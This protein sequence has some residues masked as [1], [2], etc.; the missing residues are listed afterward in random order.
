MNALNIADVLGLI[1]LGIGML[2]GFRR[3]LVKKG[4][5]LVLTLVTLFALYMVSPYV[6]G[7]F[8]QILP[9]SLLPDKITGTDSEL[10][11]MLLLSGFGDMAENYV[12]VLAAKVL[13]LVTTY[14]VIR[15]LVRTL[16][17]S[18]NILTKVPGLSL[19]NRLAGAC[20]GLVLQLLLLW[21]F[22][23][24]VAIFSGSSWGVLLDQCIKESTWMSVL[25][26]NNLL[27]LVA[28]L[29]VLKV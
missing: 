11:Q 6:E 4:A 29:L 28:I 25:Y 3:G 19:L 26:E 22:F 20:L 23:L 14:I 24:V 15:L 9:A 2:D 17:F 16:L 13:A 12:H 10:Y 27:L 21:M 18:M 7:F 8:Q 1:F 5:S